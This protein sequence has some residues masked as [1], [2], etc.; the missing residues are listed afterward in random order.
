VG[1]AF[2]LVTV[3][4]LPALATPATLKRSVENLTQF[5]L[6][7]V[8][9]PVVAGKSIYQNMNDVSD[10]TGVRIFYP[11]PGYAWNLVVQLG[12]SVIRGVTGV[13]E[14]APGMAL[15]FTDADMDPLF[16]PV[17]E[18]AALV[19]LENG[20]YDVKFGVDYTTPGF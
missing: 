19:D 5:P 9:S 15:L 6:D 4:A 10:S 1:A 18:N 7:I 17:E 11:V 20:I 13:I 8:A 14:L 12:A 2:A 16:D 3:L